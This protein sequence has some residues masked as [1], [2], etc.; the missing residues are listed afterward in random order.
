MTSHSIPE[1]ILQ[2]LDLPGI[3]TKTIK[4]IYKKLEI[5]NLEDLEEAAKEK[6]I[7]KLPGMGSKTEL[8]ILRGIG[9][10]H[11]P[12]N[13]FPL[14]VATY[15]GRDLLHILKSLNTV[16]NAAVAGEV[17]RGQEMVE[18]IEFVVEAVE[19][20]LIKR[21]L[22]NHPL[23]CKTLDD[24]KKLK[25]LTKINLPIYIH[26]CQGSFFACL[27]YFSGNKEYMNEF[28]KEIETL[29]LDLSNITSEEEIYF[30]ANMQ[31]V[32]PEIRET[33]QVIQW[34]KE[35]DIP[36]LVDLKDIKGDLHIHSNWSDGVNTIEELI[37]AAQERGYEFIAVTDH[38][39][40]LTVAGG[41]S[42]D[43]IHE[44]HNIIYKLNE[45]L[46]DFKVFTGI[47]VDILK[48]GDL[49]YPDEI[50]EQ[51]DLIIASVHNNLRQDEENI[52]AR[53][54]NAIK[55]P[56]VDILAHPTGRILGRRSCSLIDLERIF[57]LAEKTGTA[58][59]INSS[60]DRLDLNSENVRLAQM[61]NIPIA[62]NTDAH[63]I[64]SLADIELGIKTAKRGL[65]TKQSVINTWSKEDLEKW[66]KK[67]K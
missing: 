53:V 21:V 16:K 35:N 17:R 47:E 30:R 42:I 20:N 1:D 44:Q 28:A 7:R 24:S 45:A 65:L 40:S 29:G 18:K 38:S 66:L 61:F 57:I 37:E 50:M 4:E 64:K 5:K 60:P 59:E 25:L 51:T 26:F 12:P 2:L 33:P 56:H 41:L 32:P 11:N 15:I 14:G 6:R 49:D 62:I 55:N 23:V 8:A 31:F 9:L 39:R 34:A 52:T 67:K 54:E 36:D 10:L 27:H 43:E 63:N 13:S 22:S 58:M 48:A 46:S 3:E 19:R